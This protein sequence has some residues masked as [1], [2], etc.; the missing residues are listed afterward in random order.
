M[1]TFLNKGCNYFYVE[2]TFKK[3]TGF[4]DT[5]ELGTNRLCDLPQLTELSDKPGLD[6][7]IPLNPSFT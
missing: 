1:Y 5:A 3:S 6:P 4:G 2:H 7:V